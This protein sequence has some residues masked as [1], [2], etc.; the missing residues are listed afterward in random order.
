MIDGLQEDEPA[1]KDEKKS[2]L[3]MRSDTTQ[4]ALSRNSF[5]ELRI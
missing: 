3:Y 4:S 2:A 1:H 5:Y